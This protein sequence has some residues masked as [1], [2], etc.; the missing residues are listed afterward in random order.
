MRLLSRRP[1][2]RRSSMPAIR[3]P[4]VRAVEQ[5]ESRTFFNATL[6]SA[7][8]PVNA[9]GGGAPTTVDVSGNF[10]DPTITG[11]TIQIQTPLGNIPLMLFDSQTPQTVANFEHYITSGEYANVL[12]HR[13][14]PGFV[15][16]GGG[17]TANGNHIVTAGPVQGEPGVSNTTGTITMALSSGPN[18]GTS[19][20]FINLANNNGSGTTPNLDDTSDGGPFSAF[21]TVIYNGMSVVNAIAALPVGNAQGFNSA[22]TD[23]P[24][25]SIAAGLTPSNMMVTNTVNVAPLTFSATSDNP[26]LVNPVVS[27]S[28]VV[29]NYGNANGTANVTVTATDLGGNIATSTFAVTLTGTAPPLTVNVTSGHL[30]RFTDPAG[31]ASLASITGPGSATLTLLGPGLTQS[32]NKAGTVTVSGT[33][34]S[35][36]ISTTGTSLASALN[37]Q[38]VNGRVLNIAGITAD[39][40]LRA[41]NGNR[42]ALTGDLSVAGSI[43]N[44][45]LNSVL[46]GTLT[47]GGSGSALVLSVG[48]DNGAAINSSEPI[49]SIQASSLMPTQGINAPSI[50]RITVSGQVDTN[51]TAGSLGTVTAGTIGPGIWTVA[52]AVSNVTAGGITGLNLTAASVGRIT[53]RNAINNSTILSAGNIT[54][55]VAAILSGT[56][57]E[58]GS[59]TRGSNG[60][61]LSFA[62]AATIS[63]VTIGRGGFSNS[64]IGAASLGHLALGPVP[65]SSGSVPFGIVGHQ[66]LTLTATVEG[67]RLSL[68]NTTSDSQISTAFNNAGLARTALPVYVLTQTP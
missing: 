28:N 39:G 63:T 40:D 57:I 22:W 65:S 8:A 54:S 15:I 42:V 64:V 38:S 58:A 2:V 18:S 41:I 1:F 45:T 24:V 50:A 21:G 3:T 12:V 37:V 61:P 33:P 52:G 20:W 47:I 16:Q 66:I 4:S 34:Q 29:L 53:S 31:T 26:S 7:I 35:V 5:L 23:L 51:I 48:S 19:E 27:G 46:N 43:K 32:T 68:R 62:V 60:L 6:V 49:Q 13:S 17:Y 36:S 55:A 30:V 25:K 10:N 44:I 59:P 14:I 9:T 56:T 67:K 11:T